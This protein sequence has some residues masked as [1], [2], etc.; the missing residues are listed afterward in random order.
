MCVCVY[1][2]P[3]PHH[4]IVCSCPNGIWPPCMLWCVCVSKI[5]QEASR[6][7]RKIFLPPPP[8]VSCPIA[9]GCPWSNASNASWS[10]SKESQEAGQA[11]KWGLRSCM[12]N[13]CQIHIILSSHNLPPPQVPAYQLR[14][15]TSITILW[16]Q[17]RNRTLRWQDAVLLVLH[18]IGLMVATVITQNCNSVSN[19]T[20]QWET[21]TFR[22]RTPLM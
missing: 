4:I 17:L 12:C 6:E 1:P 13:C 18:R 19:H 10:K 5:L 8:P 16:R 11:E 14:Q 21:K 3:I 22:N 9:Y 20:M 15:W 7:K 2:N